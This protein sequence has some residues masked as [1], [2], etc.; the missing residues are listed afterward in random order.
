MVISLDDLQPQ[1][2]TAYSVAFNDWLAESCQ[3]NP[4]QLKPAAIWGSRRSASLGARQQLDHDVSLDGYPVDKDAG[5]PWLGRIAAPDGAQERTHLLSYPPKSS[6][7]SHV[8]SWGKKKTT[9]SP[10]PCRSMNGTIPQ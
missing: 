3:A 6:F 2:A 10:T 5:L 4:R 9:R 1:F 8:A 7:G